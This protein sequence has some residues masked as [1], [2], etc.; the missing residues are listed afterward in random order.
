MIGMT[1]GGHAGG[2]A[3]A[4]PSGEVVI[5]RFDGRELAV[6]WGPAGT[7]D[8]LAVEAGSLLTWPTADAC[9]IHARRAGWTGL[10]KE[11][12]HSISRSTLDFQ[13]AQAW[14]RGQRA[15][16]D[17]RSA[18]NL[19][20]FAGDVAG[21]IDRPWHDRGHVADRCYRKLTAANVPFLLDLTDY[22][23]RWQVNEL[24]CIRHILNDAV[25]ML[26]TALS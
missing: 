24:R 4:P 22:R 18:L 13:P 21:S 26:R 1:R 16:L 7:I 17:P 14:L 20:N 23:P 8:R 15:A 11:G 25:H 12:D 19:W 10:A 9:E 6:W 5:V 3:K 2:S